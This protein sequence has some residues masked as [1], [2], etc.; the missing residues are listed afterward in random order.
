M[1]GSDDPG[2]LLAAGRAAD[3]FDIGGGRVLRRY[4]TV[5]PDTDREARVM[6]YV[7]E[8]GF[9]VPEVHDVDGPDIVMQRVDGPT[10]YERLMAS[11]AGVL[12]HA[13]RLA[14]LQLDL[15]EI[16]APDW[17]MAPGWQPDPEGDRVLHLDLH[18]MNVIM[19]ADGPVVIDWTNAAAGP[20]GFE[21]AITYVEVA[22]FEIDDRRELVV[23]QVFLSTFR[24]MR[25]R[26]RIDPFLSAACDHR[27]ADPGLTPGE[28]EAVAELRTKLRSG[29]RRG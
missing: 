25:G 3:V 20:A 2:P 14:R 8:R 15:A 11:P 7:A 23:R 6:R 19:S 13:R 4:R 1:T 17:L 28:R 18:P 29:K 10:M 16:H 22:T 27:L 5:R 26:D 21:G 24:R 9:P 12:A